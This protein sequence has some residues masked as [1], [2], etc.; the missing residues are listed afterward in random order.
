MNAEQNYRLLCEIDANRAL[1]LQAYR[2]NPHLLAQAEARIR[3]LLGTLT[4]PDHSGNQ[5]HS[6]LPEHFHH[7]PT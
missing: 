6:L 1:L 2:Q 5:C 4:T 7:E 3:R